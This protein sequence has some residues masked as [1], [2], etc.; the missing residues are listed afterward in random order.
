[1]SIVTVPILE[2]LRSTFGG[3][4]HELRA[5]DVGLVPACRVHAALNIE[6]T[7]SI[8]F[9]VCSQE[10]WVACVCATAATHR[11]RLEG[12]ARL[13]AA[14]ELTLKSGDSNVSPEAVLARSQ[15][16]MHQARTSSG[17]ETF[18]GC[19]TPFDRGW[20]HWIDARVRADVRGAYSRVGASDREQR[21]T[22]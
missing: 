8:N 21:A 3:H 9:T 4:L 16:L 2:K 11:E 19:I 13:A 18:I 12:A 6:P 14:E 10:Q 20:V 7:L 5:G 1:M 15:A 22:A 17:R